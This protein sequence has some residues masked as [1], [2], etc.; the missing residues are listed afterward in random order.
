MRPAPRLVSLAVTA[1]AIPDTA[2]GCAPPGAVTHD[3]RPNVVKVHSA[4]QVGLS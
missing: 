3:L 4:A 1:T 2:K